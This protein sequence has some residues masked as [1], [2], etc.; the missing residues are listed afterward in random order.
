MNFSS[1][2]NEN[3]GNHQSEGEKK[4]PSQRLGKLE[5]D[6]SIFRAIGSQSGSAG[7]RYR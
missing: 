5:E 1:R 3:S 6:G 7:Q 2:V 4:F